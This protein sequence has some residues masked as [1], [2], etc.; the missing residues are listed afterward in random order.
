M[1]SG[2]Y[3][4]AIQR[5]KGAS[6]G[7]ASIPME[8]VARNPSFYS[9]LH[10]SKVDDGLVPLAVAINLFRF[11]VWTTRRQRKLDRGVWLGLVMGRRSRRA[12]AHGLIGRLH[13][14]AFSLIVPI[15]GFVNSL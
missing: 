11:A 14:N 5:V 4:A 9:V 12:A 6:A 7:L 2:P 8:Y 1:R 3:F 15:G 13:I 10:E